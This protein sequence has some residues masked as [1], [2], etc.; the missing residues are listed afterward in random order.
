[1]VEHGPSASGGHTRLVTIRGVAANRRFPIP[2]PDCCRQ[3]HVFTWFLT[4]GTGDH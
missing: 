4:E 2:A 1:M 3:I